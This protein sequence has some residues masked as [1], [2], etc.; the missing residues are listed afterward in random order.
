[1]KAALVL[2]I[3]SVGAFGQ[4]CSHTMSKAPE[5]EVLVYRNGLLQKVGVDYTLAGSSPTIT[6]IAPVSTTDTFAATLLRSYTLITTVQGK[7]W[8]GVGFAL[9]REDWVCPMT[10]LAATRITHGS[11]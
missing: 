2:L 5:G 9:W 10:P 1:M 8:I 6:F 7:P 3:F 4:T 11:I